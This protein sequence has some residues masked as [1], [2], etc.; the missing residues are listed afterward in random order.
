MCRFNG[1]NLRNAIPREAFALIAVDNIERDRAE[2]GLM[3]FQDVLNEEF[4]EIEKDLKIAIK[5]VEAPASSWILKA[6]SS[7]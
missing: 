5:E 1:G 4:G 6:R 7:F 2:S 3:D